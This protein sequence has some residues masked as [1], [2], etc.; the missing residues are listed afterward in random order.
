LPARA[1]LCAVDRVSNPD[2]TAIELELD[3]PVEIHAEA[4]HNPERVFVDLLD[5]GIASGMGSSSGLITVNVSD[6]RVPR[7]RIGRRETATRVV[8]DL[9]CRCGYS[10]KMSQQPPYRLVVTVE[11]R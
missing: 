6:P 3:R 8:L 7:I 11:A 10:Y 9:N 1:T 4:L 5:T 2:S